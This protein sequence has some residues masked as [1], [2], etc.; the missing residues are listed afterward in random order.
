MPLRSD[1]YYR[2]LAADAVRRAGIDEPPVSVTVVADRLGVPIVHAEMP[3]WFT[4]ALVYEDGMPAVL[5]N[6]AREPHIRVA[7]LGH[8]LGHLLVMLDDPATGYPKD[9]LT[10]H[11]EADVI[12][13]ELELPGFM[14][15]DQAQKWFNDYRYLARLF[16]VSEKRMLEKMGALGIIK[17]RGLMWD[18]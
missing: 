5:L 12:S 14:I 1:S 6:S 3:P 15:V 18:Y 4:S 11:H 17:N 16:G 13:E 7:G 2:D 10:N 8:V 9:S